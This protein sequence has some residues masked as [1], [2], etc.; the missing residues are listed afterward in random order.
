MPDVACWNCK[1]ML[2]YEAADRGSVVECPSCQSNIY[3]LRRG[4]ALTGRRGIIKRNEFAG[5]GS[6]VQL[7][8]IPAGIVAY[9]LVAVVMG[10]GLGII[11]G[12]GAVVTMFIVGSGMSVK[13]LCMHCHNKL[14]G[15]DVRICP[16]CQTEIGQP[17]A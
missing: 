3:L 4:D 11:F 9:V 5:I 1:A 13:Y 6:V 8:A 7:F 12:V 10:P 2:E 17:A 14:A 15:K 16:A